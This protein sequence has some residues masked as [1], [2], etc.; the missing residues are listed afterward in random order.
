MRTQA[1][2]TDTSK[3]NGVIPNQSHI[4]N[5][6]KVSATVCLTTLSLTEL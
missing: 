6:Q 2:Q 3:R 1:T 4:A 5:L